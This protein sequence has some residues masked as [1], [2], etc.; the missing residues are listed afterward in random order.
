M[1]NQLAP[2][3]E[4]DFPAG[5][6]Q[7]RKQHLVSEI[8]SASPIHLQRRSRRIAMAA[9]ALA[10]VVLIGAAYAGYVLTRPATQLESIGCYQSASL[11]ANTA[12]I[13][14]DG[15]SPAAACARIWTSAFPGA[16]RPAG[17]AACVLDSGAIGVFPKQSVADTCRQLGLAQLDQSATAQS[18]SRRFAALKS[19]LSALFTSDAC[20]GFRQARARTQEV[21]DKNG[22]S[23][24]R[25][26]PGEGVSGEGFSAERPCAG[27]AFDT[28]KQTIILVPEEN[29]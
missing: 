17:F 9:I 28:S 25:I 22:L 12:V 6:L 19:D 11:S 4:R 8:R 16:A 7:L 13:S 15:G 29:H 27:L 24:W 23:D 5:R 18:Q 2:P 10:A 26:I 21:L 3:P 1:R 20:L 14:S